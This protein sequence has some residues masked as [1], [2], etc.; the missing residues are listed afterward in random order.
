MQNF[1]RTF[2]YCTV[3]I[4]YSACFTCFIPILFL[5]IS[6]ARKSAI[7]WN[8]TITWFAKIIC[9]ITVEIRGEEYLPRN[10]GY[11]VVSKHLSAFDTF[12]MCYYFNV[13]VF[14]MKRSLFHIPF[15][16]WYL[17]RLGMIGIDRGSRVSSI[18]YM[19]QRSAEVLKDNRTIIVYPQGTRVVQRSTRKASVRSGENYREI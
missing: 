14:V 4:L 11:I 6:L 15:F 1:I 8:R 16:G 17:A 5:H 19:K 2:L 18:R 10:V 3:V 12:F 7:I 9:G 13:P